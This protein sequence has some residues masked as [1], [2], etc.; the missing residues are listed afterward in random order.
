MKKCGLLA[1]VL[2]FLLLPFSNTTEAKLSIIPPQDMIEQSSLIVI[3]HV[4]KKEYSEEE[5][6]V[7]ISVETVIKGKIKQKYIYLKRG[8]PPMYG[9]LGFDF[10]EQGTRIMVLL[11][12]NDQLTLTGDANA[13]AVLDDNNVRLYKGFTMGQFTPEKY[14]STYKAYLDVQSSQ[15]TSDKMNDKNVTS[16]PVMISY[17]GETMPAVEAKQET[18]TTLKNTSIILGCIVATIFFI[19]RILK[20]KRQN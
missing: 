8:K 2:L 12:Q 17:N 19:Y 16:M 13:V 3:G 14:E 15:I 18:F 9:W 6:Q 20:R 7:V 11:Q 4:T 10:P 1:L 5:R